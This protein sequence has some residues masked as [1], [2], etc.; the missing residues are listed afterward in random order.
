MTHTHISNVTL[1]VTLAGR[2]QV[3]CEGQTEM[4]VWRKAGKTV[5]SV[6][7]LRAQ[8]SRHREQ[9]QSDFYQDRTGKPEMLSRPREPQPDER[10]DQAW[11]S[12]P[13]AP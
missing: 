7:F 6:T 10:G 11:A 5:A 9:K 3:I 4:A 12:Q 2:W 13:L 1:G 8:Q